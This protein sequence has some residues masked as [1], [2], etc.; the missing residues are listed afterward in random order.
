VTPVRVLYA[1]I[2]SIALIVGG[3]WLYQHHNQAVADAAIVQADQ[4]H[5]QA[6]SNAA[7]GAVHDQSI[8]TAKSHL[9]ADAQETKRLRSEVERLRKIIAAPVAMDAPP[10]D[11]A[12]LVASQD[13]LIVGLTKE[14]DGMKGQVVNLTLSRDSWKTAYDASTR[15]VAS[16]RL[17]HEAQVA[18]IRGSRWMGRVEGFAVGMAAGYVAGMR[19]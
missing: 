4:H 1:L 7:Q 11:L 17:A 6:I 18:A 15:E 5:E 9:D 14:N 10:V 12:P 8:E 3:V 2:A 19:K 16:L 13:A